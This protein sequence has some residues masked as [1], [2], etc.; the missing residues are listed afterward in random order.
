M[1]LDT[2]Q[3]RT[4]V[5]FADAGS[6]KGAAQMVYK[7]PSAVSLHLSKLVRTLS[8]NLLQHQ[9]RRLVLT[10]DGTELVR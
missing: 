8:R 9:G 6:C 3:V 7:T 4:L 5:A 1:L 10:H 2:E